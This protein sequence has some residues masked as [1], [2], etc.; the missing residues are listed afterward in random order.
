MVEF[1]KQE[2]RIMAILGTKKLDVT[3]ATLKR[4][5][6]YLKRHVEFPCQLTGIEDFD[7][8]E[9]Y[10]FGPG[11]KR[12]YEELKEIQPSYKDK[13]NLIDFVDNFDDWEDGIFVVVRRESDRK[14]FVLPLADLKATD[15]KSKNYQLL[16]DYSV[17]FVNY[18]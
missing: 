5:L 17:W 8:E 14:K 1:D 4:Y 11:N 2:K 13:F 9:S 7:W 16:D 3:R 12:E 18:R 6:K 10:V 15:K